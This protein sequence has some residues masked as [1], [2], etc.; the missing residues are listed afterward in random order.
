MSLANVFRRFVGGSDQ[1]LDEAVRKANFDRWHKQSKVKQPVY[2]ATMADE[3][4]DTF[5]RG[6]IGYHFGTKGAAEDRFSSLGAK[7]AMWDEPEYLEGARVLPVHLS[8]QNPIHLPDMGGWDVPQ[9]WREDFLAQPDEDLARWFPDPYLRN[10][11]QMAAETALG[12]RFDPNPAFAEEI[13]RILKA[14]GYDGV[15][16]RNAYEDPGRMSYIAFEPTQIKS[17]FNQGT[18]DPTNPSF[19]KAG[20]GGAVGLAALGG[21]EDTEAAPGFRLQNVMSMLRPI[22]EVKA[23]V[24]NPVL[25]EQTY[26]MAELI[27][28]QFQ[29]AQQQGV[30]PRDLLKSYGITTSS[31]QRGALDAGQFPPTMRGGETGLL[32]PEDA[33]ANWFTSPPGQDY[34]DSTLAGATDPATVQNLRE[35][36]RPYGMADVLAGQMLRAGDTVLPD[37]PVF[38]Q[39]IAGGMSPDEVL[40]YFATAGTVPGIGPVKAGFQL[41]MLGRGDLPVPDANQ[42]NL[43][44]APGGKNLVDELNPRQKA[45]VVKEIANRQSAIGMQMPERYEPLRQYLTH[46]D[47][48]DRTLGTQ[49]THQPIINAMRYG[50]MGGAAAGLGALASPGDTQAATLSRE[51]SHQQPQVP[52]VTTAV[53]DLIRDAVADPENA[54]GLLGLFG[55]MLTMPRSLAGPEAGRHS[56]TFY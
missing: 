54:L 19:L 29:K 52:P 46:H 17:V 1:L 9:R 20:A 10:D 36:F 39:M 55:S 16:Y 38:Q 26:P 22:D 13:R 7:G 27:L 48:W 21:S 56:P 40:A 42:L 43:H 35:G 32:R 31:V 25:G 3:D 33:M 8:L 47:V 34:L 49:T 6:D 53:S 11:I 18:Y 5:A 30:S 44:L 12:P 23:A 51:M 15:Q 28:E 50:G 4:F 2:H 37:L 45:Q 14:H 41:P 24:G